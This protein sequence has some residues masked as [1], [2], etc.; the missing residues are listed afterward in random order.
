MQIAVF[1]SDEEGSGKSFLADEL[2]FSLERTHVPFQF[3]T[4]GA[5]DTTHQNQSNPDAEILIVDVKGGLPEPGRAYGDALYTL[6]QASSLVVIPQTGTI[7][8]PCDAVEFALT[9]EESAKAVREINPD[10]AILLVHNFRKNQK[11]GA[12]VDEELKSL[13]TDAQ[14][15]A[16]PQMEI[17]HVGRRVR[18]SGTDLMPLHPDSQKLSSFVNKARMQLGLAAERSLNAGPPRPLATRRQADEFNVSPKGG[19]A[20]FN[21]FSRSRGYGYSR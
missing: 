1:L 11:L 13:D 21:D 5:G 7:Y 17:V 6:L 12:L 14:V 20:Y 8:F 9:M 16:L 19:G 3:H 18:R 15:V 2:A 4:T 10:A